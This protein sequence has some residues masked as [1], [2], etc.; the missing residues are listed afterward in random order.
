MPV[1]HTIPIT[2]MGGTGG[3]F[4]C[5]FIVSAKKNIKD[6]VQLSPYGNA[7]DYG[8][9]DFVKTS[10]KIIGP[11]I[12]KINFILNQSVLTSDAVEPYYTS[13]HVVNL[14]LATTHFAKVIRITYDL[15]DTPDL[16]KVMFGKWY[17][18]VCNQPPADENAN[19]A[20]PA[21]LEIVLRVYANRFK[22]EDFPDVLFI[23]WKELFKGNIEELVNK[24]SS[25]TN[26]DSNNFS[27]SS[28]TH[29]RNKTQQ[30][31][32]NLSEV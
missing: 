2:Y 8:M 23:S 6:T 13:T 17:I 15:D 29:W 1:S 7:H 25:F 11:D 31:I 32:D 4:L 24:I 10:L 22:K 20:T 14:K 16:S 21:S 19:T 9:R 27:I 18:D 5:H 28:L 12:D 3:N 30:C 26:I